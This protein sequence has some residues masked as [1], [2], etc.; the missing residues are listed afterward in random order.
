MDLEIDTAQGLSTLSKSELEGEIDLAKRLGNYPEQLINSATNLE[1]HALTHYLRDL[2]S[3]FHT[4]Y[5]SN[6][7]LVDDA[8]I[9]NTRIILCLA[10]KQVI[11]NGLELLGVNAPEEM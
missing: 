6:K 2:A 10:V 11:K 8:D 3:E 4:Y 7:V 9:R 1:P 5:N